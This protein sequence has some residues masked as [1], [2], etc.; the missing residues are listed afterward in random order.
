MSLK[1]RKK[2]FEGLAKARV[3]GFSSFRRLYPSAVSVKATA[4]G[5]CTLI[6]N[7]ARYDV[8][9][10]KTLFIKERILAGTEIR[11]EKKQSTVT[12][13]TTETVTTTTTDDQ[14][15]DYAG[16]AD[17]PTPPAGYSW[18]LIGEDIEGYTPDD[19]RYTYNSYELQNVDEETC[20]FFY[21]MLTWDAGYDARS[22]GNWSVEITTTEEVEVTTTTRVYKALSVSFVFSFPEQSITVS[23]GDS[24]D[25]QGR[26]RFLIPLPS[27]FAYSVPIRSA[28]DLDTSTRGVSAYPDCR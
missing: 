11:V 5:D 10:G 2:F 8:E 23:G 21:K 27:P 19:E 18:V 25:K 9:N 3:L 14:S 15:F 4:D 22:T 20:G 7:S 26:I 28:F 1:N 24:S 6:I 12:T 17:P 13:T 16:M